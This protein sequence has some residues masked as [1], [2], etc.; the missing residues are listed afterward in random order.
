MRYRIAL[1]HGIED[2]RTVGHRGTDR[3]PGTEAI[4]A[5]RRRRPVAQ[6]LGGEE[7]ARQRDDR[8]IA[9]PPSPEYA[10]DALRRWLPLPS[11]G[12]GHAVHQGDEVSERAAV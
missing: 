12:G 5:R 10:E 6:H 3:G 2:A 4:L 7:I 11:F 1:A 9:A 8:M